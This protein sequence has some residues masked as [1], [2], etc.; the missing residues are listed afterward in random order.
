MNMKFLVFAL[1]M[2]GTAFLVLLSG[3]ALPSVL[4]ITI[5]ILA[6][7]SDFLTTWLCLRKNG[8]E[9]NPIMAFLFKKIGL[10]KS[11]GVLLGIWVLII[12][13]RV[14]PAPPIVQ[15]A[16]AFSYWLVPA[17]NVLVLIRLHRKQRMT[18]LEKEAV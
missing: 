1:L 9:G 3:F 6:V 2:L 4:A 14:L 7:L 10:F 16:L 12:V 5:F 13:F 8:K 15:T 18:S 17:N 11:Y